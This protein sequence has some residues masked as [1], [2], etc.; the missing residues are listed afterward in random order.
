MKVISS[1]LILNNKGFLHKL[2]LKSTQLF[3]PS[4]LKL[5]LLYLECRINVKKNKISEMETKSYLM[6]KMEPFSEMRLQPRGISMHLGP[7]ITCSLSPDLLLIIIH[8]NVL[9]C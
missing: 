5:V 8:E 6:Y 9:P 1:K 7:S 2:C 3:D 4:R